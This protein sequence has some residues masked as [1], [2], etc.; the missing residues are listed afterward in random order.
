M[1]LTA[2][3]RRL[4]N[5]AEMKRT[6]DRLLLLSLTPGALW[7]GSRLATNSFGSIPVECLLCGVATLILF[8]GLSRR[9][10]DLGPPAIESVVQATLLALVLAFFSGL[11]VATLIS[12]AWGP[13]QPINFGA[14]LVAVTCIAAFGAALAVVLSASATSTIQQRLRHVVCGSQLFLPLLCAVVIPPA[15]VANRQVFVPEPSWLLN[16]ALLIVMAAGWISLVRRWRQR[17]DD[18][19]DNLTR[20]LTL[21]SV[22]PIA[23]FVAVNHGELSTFIGDDFHVGEHLLPWQQLRD[24]G[25]LPFVGFVPVHPLMDLIVGGVNDLFFDGTLA[26]YDNSR[27]ILFAIGT[28]LTFAAVFRFGGAGFALCLA[29]AGAVWDRLL[30]VPVAVAILCNG[31]LL[32]RRA[33]WLICASLVCILCGCYN[34]AAGLALTLAVTPVAISQACRLFIEDRKALYR[35]ASVMGLVLLLICVIPPCRAILFGFA[36]FLIDNGKTV[37]MAHGYNWQ[38]EAGQLPPLKG[39]L[40]VPILWESLRFSWIIVL[41]AAAALFVTRLPNWRTGDRWPFITSSVVCLFLFFLANWSLNRIDPIN[42]SRTGEVSCLAVLYLLPLALVASGWWRAS[43]IPLFVFAAGFFHQG[44]SGFLNSASK[45]HQPLTMQTL[46]EKP[47]SVISLPPTSVLIDGKAAG[48]PNL[49]KM[50]APAQTAR[51]I[52]DL[53][54]AVNALLRPGETFFDLTNRQANY[55]Y[56]GLPVACSYGAPWLAGNTVLQERLLNELVAH[57]PALVWIAPPLTHDNGTAS[58]RTYKIYRYLVQHYVPIER[59]RN[60]FMIAS[61]RATEL[62]P[63]AD[64]QRGLLRAAFDNPNLAQLPSAWGSS[65][66]LLSHRFATT[67]QLNPVATPGPNGSALSL[68]DNASDIDGLT[69]D[70]LKFDFVSNLSPTDRMDL[71]ISWTGEH[72]RGVARLSATEGTNLVPLGAF[73][74]W[75]L[76]R[77]ISNVQMRPL[78]PPPN[79]QCSVR[80]AQLL[81][82][83]D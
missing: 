32:S 65:W 72:G 31:S 13:V 35:L 57:P 46:V 12:R 82:L 49:G 77:Q 73:P 17:P 53:H 27:A 38:L 43:Y 63:P 74:D 19:P 44:F 1:V 29:L 34:P 26:N 50:F 23:I 28:G 5:I 39:A 64:K 8:F 18:L 37:A 68:G 61:E 52:A 70:F 69:N 21:L 66:T 2:L 83:K 25:K 56:L 59:G 71:E 41:L 60:I 55:F 6:L 11:G 9:R 33:Q 22:L 3:A 36:R 47:T 45:P 7:L 81:R 58:L 80:N 16:G 42:P 62:A 51:T 24:F 75:L 76:S 10:L 79:L 54:N 15:I 78:S 14:R 40:A 67:R 30:F 48:L 20:D 4:P